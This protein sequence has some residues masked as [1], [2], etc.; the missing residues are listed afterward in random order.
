MATLTVQ[1][2]SPSGLV[3][4]LAA[5]D[6]AG[7][8]FANAGKTYL[9]VH[10]ASGGSITV[11]IVGQKVCNQGFLHDGG[12]SV[13]DGVTKRFGPF[14][15]DRFNDADNLVQVTYSAVTSVTVAAVKP[16]P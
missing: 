3:V 14:P 8:E 15:V 9:D 16:A 5:A 12:G 7:D 6:V 1:E 4:S 2:S 10:N 11:T 13:A